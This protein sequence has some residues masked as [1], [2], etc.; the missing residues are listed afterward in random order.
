[1]LK[2]LA[3]KLYSIETEIKSFHYNEWKQRQI[4]EEAA[5]VSDFSFE[6]RLDKPNWVIIDHHPYEHQPKNAT[7]IFDAN[8]SAGLLCYELCKS[9]GI[10]SEELDLLV[11]YSNVADLFLEDDPDFILAND[12]ANLVKTYGFWNLLA[13]IGGRIESLLNHPL[14]EVMAIKRK[15]E[16]T[17]WI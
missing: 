13:L 14:L 10:Q 16:R 12:Y 5:W 7:V 3:Q 4:N 6:P 15:L 9:A 1:L 8:K 2:R 17:S 11:H